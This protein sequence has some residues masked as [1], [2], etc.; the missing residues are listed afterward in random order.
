MNDQFRLLALRREA[1]CARSEELRA[2]IGADARAISARLQA[3]DRI[4]AVARSGT[5]RALLVAAAAFMVIGR[6]RHV[7]K[8]GM[9]ALALW[10]LI[11]AVAPRLQG[12]VDAF[13]RPPGASV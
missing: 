2:S 5:A 6:P 12:L 9:R 4:V 10:P 1:L 3:A 13:R 8:L 11:S 7:L